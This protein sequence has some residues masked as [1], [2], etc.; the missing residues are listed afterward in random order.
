M[1]QERQEILNEIGQD[2]VPREKAMLISF[3]TLNLG[4]LREEAEELA[5]FTIEDMMQLAC[6]RKSKGKPWKMLFQTF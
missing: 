6:E 3:G 1:N 4:M 5:E 2:W